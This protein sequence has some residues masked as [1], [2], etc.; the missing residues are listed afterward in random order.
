MTGHH[1]PIAQNRHAVG[2]GP[3]FLDTV[4]DVDDP[5]AGLLEPR[6]LLDKPLHLAIS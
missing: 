3:H 2:N 4:R 5:D 1:L 6:D